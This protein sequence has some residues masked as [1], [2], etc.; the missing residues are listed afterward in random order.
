VTDRT[1]LDT[2]DAHAARYAEL[3]TPMHDGAL[4]ELMAEAARLAGPGADALEVG[5]GPG[6]EAV[7]LERL[8]LR[9]QRTDGSAA[10]VAMLR[11][12]GHEADLLDVRSDDLRPTTGGRYGVLLAHAVLLHLDRAELRD[13]LARA[14]DA[15]GV[16][17]ITV[18]EGDGEGWSRA[19]LDAPRWFTYWR[20]EP[21]REVL[22]ATGWRVRRLDHVT[23]R[24]PW[25]FVLAD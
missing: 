24:E 10:F 9:V 13:A 19:K 12:Q 21:L 8:G 4:R 25:L 1:T 22:S 6:H 20:E 23:A 17:V 2:Y 3:S 14:R 15:A 7:E 5:S 18:K 11:A 16:L